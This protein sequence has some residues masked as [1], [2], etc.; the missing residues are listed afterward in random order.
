MRLLFCFFLFFFRYNRSRSNLFLRLFNLLRLLFFRFNF[1]L[2]FRFFICFWF[3]KSVQIYFINNLNARRFSFFLRFCF[4][5]FYTLW[6]FYFLRFFNL[7]F[8]RFFLLRFK[9]SQHVWSSK[10]FQKKSLLF[11]CKFRVEIFFNT[12][13]F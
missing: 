13:T 12:V 6:F 1:N 3:I 9:L 4:W 10:F 2:W 8:F 5:S 11:A 7:C